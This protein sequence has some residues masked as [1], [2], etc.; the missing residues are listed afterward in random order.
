MCPHS[1]RRQLVLAH[2]EVDDG[3]WQIIKAGKFV[4]VYAQRLKLL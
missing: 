2:V 3:A 4:A 1:K